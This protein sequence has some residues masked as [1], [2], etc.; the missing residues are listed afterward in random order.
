MK[1]SGYIFRTLTLM[2]VIMFSISCGKNDDGGQGSGSGDSGGT[3]E[4]PS[5]FGKADL[6]GTFTDSQTGAGIAGVAV[7]DGFT[8]TKTNSRGEY[9]LNRNKMTRKVYY[10]TPEDYEINLDP[11]TGRPVFYSDGILPEEGKIRKDFKLTRLKAAEKH[12]TILAVGDPQCADN[13]AVSRFRTET[14]ADM[15]ATVASL[16]DANVYAITLGDIIYDSNDMWEPCAEAMASLSVSG[17]RVPFFQ[18]IG[19]HLTFFTASFIQ[20][21]STNIIKIFCQIKMFQNLFC[22]RFRL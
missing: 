13:V 22:V 12:L 9:G 2:A 3:E 15:N 5:P 6:Y 17:R 16:P 1:K 14:I 10:C 8:F 18:C 20:I 7:T 19:N 4:E 11:S 21:T